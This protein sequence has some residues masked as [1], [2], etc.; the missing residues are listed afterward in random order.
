[1]AIGLY[2]EL[3]WENKR[4]GRGV[5]GQFKKDVLSQ[6]RK[7]A[8]KTTISFEFFLAALRLCEKLLTETDPPPV[9]FHAYLTQRSQRDAD[10]FTFVAVSVGAL[11]VALFAGYVPA[12]RATKVDPLVALRNDGFRPLSFSGCDRLEFVVAA[13]FYSR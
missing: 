5:V 10:A 1:V 8:K 6:S 9:E 13:G 3:V 7:V 4:R 2:N 11:A 12:R